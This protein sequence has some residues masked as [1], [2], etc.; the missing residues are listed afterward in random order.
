[1]VARYDGHVAQYLG[2]G[3]M[4][5]F[6]WPDAHEDDAERCVRAA[7][8]IVQA[9]KGVA[10]AEALA[11]RIGVATGPVVVGEAS[12]DGKRE[13]GLAVGETPNLA[14]RLQGLA[15]RRRDRDRA[16]HAAAGRQYASS[17]TDL[18]AHP[19]KGIV[20]AGA[21][22]ARGGLRRTEGR[23]DAAHGGVR[24][25]AAGGAR[26][27]GGAAAAPLAARRAAAK[28]RS[29]L[30][31]GEPGIGK[32][33]LTQVLREQIKGEPHTALRYQCSPFHLNSALYPII[34]QI[35]FAA[36]FARED[37]AEQKL[38]KLE[39]MLVGSQAQRAEVGAAVC[40]AAL[41]AHRPLS[42]ARTLAAEAEGEDARGAGRPGRSAVPAS[43]RC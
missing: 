25:D 9:V 41:A 2:D 39:A 24:A 43:S 5:Y 22:L 34:E 29:C 12:S 6:G 4:V 32:S 1:M 36:G 42:A 40:R 13:D 3:L 35:E 19:L 14:A 30:V 26:G 20:A 28:D 8:E 10:V 27:R 15:G 7:L 23:F 37:T 18:G 38:D 11:V 31:G 17:S 21:G 16:R 33:R